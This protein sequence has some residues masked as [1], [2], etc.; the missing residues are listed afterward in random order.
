MDL[1]K[2]FR[3]LTAPQMWYEK[4]GLTKLHAA[5]IKMRYKKGQVS[6]DKMREL[7]KKSGFKIIQEEVWKRPEKKIRFAFE[8]KVVTQQ[9][10]MLFS[11]ESKKESDFIRIRADDEV[12]FSGYKKDLIKLLGFVPN[13]RTPYRVPTSIT[14][15][16][17]T[18]SVKNI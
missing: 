12:V 5:M 2:A 6:E 10:P 1:H 16:F 11:I 9:D 13:K 7:L 18:A 4:C 14:E 3:Q 17:K 8:E 15:Q